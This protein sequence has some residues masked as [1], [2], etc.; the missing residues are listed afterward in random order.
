MS[1]SKFVNNS[2]KW[3]AAAGRECQIPEVHLPGV[4]SSPEQ[5]QFARSEVARLMHEGEPIMVR[6]T[7]MQYRWSTNAIGAGKQLVGRL[8]NLTVAPQEFTPNEAAVASGF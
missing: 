7:C 4:G 6:G 5:I 2:K 8:C 1:Y 3:A